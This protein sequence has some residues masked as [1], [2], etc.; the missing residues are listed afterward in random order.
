[1]PIMDK[2]ILL[3]GQY[4]W[5]VTKEGLFNIYIGPMGLSDISEDEAFVVPDPEN[6]GEL[7]EVTNFKDGIQKFVTI[8]GQEYVMMH[9][10]TKDGKPTRPN[11][12]FTVKA[13]NAMA[14]LEYGSEKVI[15]DGHFPL[16]P[17]Q[18]IDVR[19]V[20][21]IESDEYLIVEIKDEEVDAEAPYYPLLVQCAKI[22][23]AVVD[24]TVET[25]EGEGV[26]TTADLETDKSVKEDGETIGSDDLEVSDSSEETQAD[27]TE[28][29]KDVET[30]DEG[31]AKSLAGE[32]LYDFKRGQRVIIMGSLTQEFIPPTGTDVVKE[33]IEEKSKEDDS[34]AESFVTA[35]PDME[36]VDEIEAMIYKKIIT[37][38][39]YAALFEKA[40]LDP[41]TYSIPRAYSIYSDDSDDPSALLSAFRHEMSAY[42]FK[43]LIAAAAPPEVKPFAEKRKSIDGIIRK[44]IVLGPTE[45]CVLLNEEGNPKYH[46]GPGRVFPGP[47]DTIL[48]DDSRNAVY[49]AYHIRPDRAILIR[50]IAK[51][52][53]KEELLSKLPVGTPE[54]FLEKDKYGKGDEIFLGGFDAYVVPHSSFEVILP[55]TRTPHRGNNHEGVYV[56]AIGVDQKSGIY[57]ADIETG[58]VN[59]V[60]GEK[61]VWIDPRKD[62]HMKRKVP[63]NIWD[64]LIA[65]TEAHKT[66]DISLIETPW[67]LSV[68]VPNNE[69][70]MITAKDG[71]RVVVGPCTELFEFEEVPEILTLSRGKQKSDVTLLETCF[72]RITGNTVSDMIKLTTADQ[73]PITVSLQYGL[74]FF[75]PDD[76]ENPDAE[77]EKWFNDKNYVGMFTRNLRS[78]L[79]AEAETTQLMEIA[80]DMAGF[81][82]D[83]VLGVKK[84][85]DKHRPGLTFSDIN[86]KIVEVDLIDWKI[87]NEEISQA[88]Q[89][90][91]TSAV[92]RMLEDLEQESELESNRL[93][94]RVADENATIEIDNAKRDK[95]T[96]KTKKAITHLQLM[97][98]NALAHKRNIENQKRADVITEAIQ[99]RADE[100]ADR[101]SG[102]M[103]AA[104]NL[105]D[106]ITERRRTAAMKFLSSKQAIEESLLKTQ[107]TV[108]VDMFRAIEPKLIEAI[109]GHGKQVMLAEFA[110]NLP[111]AGGA[112]GIL[113]QGG[114]LAGFKALTENLGFE[115]VFDALNK[116]VTDL[117]EKSVLT[118]AED[119]EG[120]DLDSIDDNADE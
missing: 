15:T 101:E 69:A 12:S 8:K 20:H 93:R 104:A 108:A 61:K 99:K 51:S 16:W 39:N 92:T 102:R 106:E 96:A 89:R 49:D 4:L 107:G 2:K 19:P 10:P 17:G 80:K 87:N 64:L 54:A 7:L 116:S 84:E 46:E 30:V 60:R 83:A 75:V 70:L 110:K 31:K 77:R 109:E 52:I 27:D 63:K 28:I 11:D 85:D 118:T 44:A 112:L 38:Q 119:L 41:D 34:G 81:I 95:T 14:L 35:N 72:L 65:H 53:S 24:T 105:Q 98:E 36:P 78:R 67:A 79:S 120:K 13:K 114:G 48:T 5:T 100:V 40:G 50:I 97:H 3:P 26:T 68:P 103:V 37:P 58:T 56:Q 23:K 115:K 25:T 42:E 1:M 45:F 33:A 82:R 91:N 76:A 6:S 62:K 55:E 94:K 21:R 32:K 57:V 9:N 71:R 90:S 113:L 111:E 22:D 117:D 18:F 47:N 86:M 74:E 43:K 29:T 66:A 88:L 73:V 59:L